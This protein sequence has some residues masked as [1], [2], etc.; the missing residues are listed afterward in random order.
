M[1]V[2]DRPSPDAPSLTQAIIVQMVYCIILASRELPVLPWPKKKKTATT[3]MHKI[4]TLFL[5]HNITRLARWRG[6][7][8][9]R[10]SLH[11]SAVKLNFLIS[12]DRNSV[13]ILCII[14]VAVFFFFF[15]QVISSNVFSEKGTQKK[16]ENNKRN[17]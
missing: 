3:I 11:R 15:G 16:N 14:L 9:L 12:H 17:H 7:P 8:R 1:Q 6:L 2:T 4:R 10:A 5:S 13:L